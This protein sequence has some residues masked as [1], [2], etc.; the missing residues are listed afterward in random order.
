MTN[1]NVR[2]KIKGKHIERDYK[3]VGEGIEDMS[4]SIFVRQNNMIEDDFSAGLIWNMPSGETLTL[5]RYNGSS[6][7]H[8]NPLEETRLNRTCHIHTATQRYILKNKKAECF[9]EETNRYQTVE[10]ALHCLLLDC[11]VSGIQSTPDE[12]R[13]L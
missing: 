7:E 8:R 5:C 9:A 1:P 2:N 4:F 10:G 11:N 13:L 12:P 3:V 6:H